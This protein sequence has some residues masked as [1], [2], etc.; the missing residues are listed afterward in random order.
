[1]AQAMV[2]DEVV[3]A[4]TDLERTAPPF[5]FE[6]VGLPRQLKYSPDDSRSLVVQLSGL[7]ATHS[8]DVDVDQL[9]LVRRQEPQG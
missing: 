5:E 8:H 2:L 4:P 1:M 7:V 6:W 3:C 9:A